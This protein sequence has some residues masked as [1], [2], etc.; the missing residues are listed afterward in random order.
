MFIPSLTALLI[1]I[2]FFGFGIPL[3]LIYR[4]DSRRHEALWWGLAYCMAGIGF[5][6]EFFRPSMPHLL[7]VYLSNWFYLVASGLIVH[8]LACRYRQPWAAQI[9]IVFGALTLAALIVCDVGFNDVNYRT[10]TIH[11]GVTAMFL[12]G[13]LA[14]RPKPFR[15]MD[16]VLWGLTLVSGLQFGIRAVAVMAATGFVL[17]EENY[18]SSFFMTLMHLFVAGFGV[19][20]AVGL[21][22][23][24]A[25]DML[26]EFDHNSTTDSLS[27]VRNRQGFDKFGQTLADEAARL[28]K[29]MAVVICDIDRFKSINDSHGHAFGDAVIAKM[30]QILR[31]TVRE[32]DCIGRIGGEE[33]AVLT[34]TVDERDGVGLAGRLRKSF[35]VTPFETQ[36]GPMYFTASFGVATLHPGDTLERALARA[37]KA[38]YEAKDAGRNTVIVWD[39]GS[40]RLAGAM[41][42]HG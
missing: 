13:V 37:D 11:L 8:G 14:I 27:G 38:L 41:P 24:V 9:N 31:D 4:Y 12:I 3:L 23:A 7:V 6:A 26:A 34:V 22:A 39:G 2:I 1:P 35:A 29:S 10:L 32:G 33:F 15:P 5:F 40:D 30:G 36:E 42:V 25:I 21:L 17:T 18:V 20:M 16:W 28:N 19:A